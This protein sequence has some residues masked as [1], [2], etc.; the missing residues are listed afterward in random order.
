MERKISTAKIIIIKKTIFNYWYVKVLY[1]LFII[2]HDIMKT[3]WN[4]ASIK[5]DRGLKKTQY[6]DSIPTGKRDFWWWPPHLNSLQTNCQFCFT[7]N[8]VN[9][10][11]KVV[12]NSV[13]F[14]Q[15]D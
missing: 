1:I 14:R 8:L 2:F 12:I 13:K 5:E 6:Y 10:Q 7:D 3:E 4:S 11:P 15:Q 9:F